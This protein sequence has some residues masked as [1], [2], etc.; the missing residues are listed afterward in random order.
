MDAVIMGLL[1]FGGTALFLFLPVGT[2]FRL[3]QL[4]RDQQEGFESLTRA[5]SRLQS[6]ITQLQRPTEATAKQTAEQPV[7]IKR[8]PIVTAAREPIAASTATAAASFAPA[9]REA[10]PFTWPEV[11]PAPPREPS[12]FETAAKETLRRIWNWIIVGE[13]HVPDG[14]SMEYAVASQWL[15]RIGVLILVVGVG[16]FLKYSIDHGLLGPVA[17]RHSRPSPVW[18]CSSS[19]RSS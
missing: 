2:F 6:H 8:E 7:E 19:E 16:F 12:R 18:Q 3:R 9:A 1:V 13:E 11:K 4:Q 15:L 14:V 5:L 17:S 10:E